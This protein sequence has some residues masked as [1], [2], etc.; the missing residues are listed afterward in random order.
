MGKNPRDY[1]GTMS[2]GE[3]GRPMTRGEKRVSFKI[4]GKTFSYIQPGWWCS[5]TDPDDMEGQLVDEDNQ[6]AD[7]A[8]R[9]A[10]RRPH[11]T[12]L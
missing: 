2:S 4:E 8:R 10:E 9:A 12:T 1:P 6:V 3:S 11:S 7:L 5:L